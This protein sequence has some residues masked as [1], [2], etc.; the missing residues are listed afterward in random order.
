MNIAEQK[1]YDEWVACL[2][3]GDTVITRLGY[4][5]NR[6]EEISKVARITRTLIVLEG[7]QRFRRRDGYQYEAPTGYGARGCLLKPTKEALQRVR[8]AQA[9]ATL[10]GL[11]V[12]KLNDA[13]VFAMVKAMSDHADKVV[14]GGD[15]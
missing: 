2:K 12:E 10:R 4:S 15:V 5:F 3:E 9:R 7:G 8:L 1:A 14:E 13:Q 6:R 11:S